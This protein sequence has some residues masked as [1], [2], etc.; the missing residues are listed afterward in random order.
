ME[1]KR[2]EKTV[3]KLKKRWGMEE[4]GHKSSKMRKLPEGNAGK[5]EGMLDTESSRWKKVRRR[6]STESNGCW[7]SGQGSL[8]GDEQGYQH[9]SVEGFRKE[10][11]ES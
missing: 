7:G 9:L 11:Q 1:G 5:P 2:E 10:T 8:Q 6:R 3:D 4:N